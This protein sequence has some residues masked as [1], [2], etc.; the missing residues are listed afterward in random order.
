MKGD[1]RIKPE[2]F[3]PQVLETFVKISDLFN[4]TFEKYKDE[5]STFIDRTD[6]FGV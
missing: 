5:K 3:D 4:D 2:D 6:I 1:G